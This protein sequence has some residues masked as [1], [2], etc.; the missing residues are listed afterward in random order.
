MI[1]IRRKLW[2]IGRIPAT[3]RF[4]YAILYL[5]LAA[6]LALMRIMSMRDWRIASLLRRL[7]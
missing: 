1:R 4:E 5:G 6:V 2:P 3:T 7:R